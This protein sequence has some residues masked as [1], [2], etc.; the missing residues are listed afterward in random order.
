MIRLGIAGIGTIARDYIGLIAAG[1]VKDVELTALCSRSDVSLHRLQ[2]QYSLSAKVFQDYRTMLDSDVVDA[3]LITTPH[4]LHPEMAIQAVNAGIHVLVEKPVGIY[5]DEVEQVLA[6]LEK[7]P[8]IVCGVMYNRRASRCFRTVKQMVEQGQIGEL[9]RCT[10]VI[11]DLYRT[12]AYYTSGSWRGSWQ[13][14][15]G[16]IL[17][18]QAS[19]QLDLMQWICGMPVSVQARCTTQNRPIKVENEAELFLTYPNG[20]HGHFIA[21]AHECPGRNMLEICGTRGRITVENDRALELLLLE[22]DEREFTR[23]C[24]LPFEKAPYTMAV[25]APK[26]GYVDRILAEEIGIACMTLGGG[27]ETKESSIDLSVGIILKKKNG[28]FV[29]EGETIA[30]VYGN[31]TGKMERAM[32]KIQN[33][34]EITAEKPEGRPVV[35]KYIK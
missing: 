29:K 23:M 30:V 28:D 27:R 35:L 8:E 7:R 22:Q 17:M 24:P 19:H 1:C 3:V 20:A 32:E 31:D 14:E 26:S 21:S 11:T 33:A 6:A 9:V 12:D 18:T 10:W 2:T 15:G 5:C 13:S 4:G 16:G 25:A 34:Y